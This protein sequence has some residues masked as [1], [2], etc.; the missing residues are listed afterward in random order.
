[1]LL[2]CV[3]R[4]TQDGD[5]DLPLSDSL[6]TEGQQY[7]SIGDY[8]NDYYILAEFPIRGRRDVFHKPNFIPLSSIDE[9]EMVREYQTERV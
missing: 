1:M 3:K 4:D 5:T 2:L 7:N 9:T 6:L 8:D